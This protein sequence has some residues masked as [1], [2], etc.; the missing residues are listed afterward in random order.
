MTAKAV[1]RRGFWCVSIHWK[2]RRACHRVEPSTRERAEA[3]AEATRQ[4]LKTYGMEAFDILFGKPEAEVE[5]PKAPEL[6]KDFGAR[7]LKE[8]ERADLKTSTKRM[9]ESNWENH[10]LPALGDV[11][12]QSIDYALLK[13]FILDKRDAKYE[14]GRFRGDPEKRHKKYLKNE[15]RHYSK[16]TIRV[17]TMTLRALLGEAV[18]EKLL[19]ENPVKDLSQFY[20]KRKKEKIVTRNQVYSLAELHAIEA[21]LASNRTLYGDDYELALCQGRTGMRIGEA[22]A[23]TPDDFD[24]DAKTIRI[25]RNIPSG[26][27]IAEDS[28]KTDAGERMIDMP[29]ELVTALRSMLVNRKAEAFKAGKRAKGTMFPIRYEDFHED[30]RRAQNQLGI[31][32]RSPHSIRHTWASTMLSE[33]ADIAWVSHQLGHSSPAVTLGIYTHF[34]PGKKPKV[35]D[36]MDRCKKGENANKTQTQSHE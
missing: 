8:I 9:Y 18:R 7:W 27:G 4:A 12:V 31:R 11:A 29:D 20:R 23:L 24:W 2:K 10:I 28:T 25:E 17:M 33:G 32:Y 19:P 26:I 22:R 6:L 1:L 14:T 30:W 35:I 3:V 5:T 16:D 36:A 15:R 21:H 34:I 13:Q